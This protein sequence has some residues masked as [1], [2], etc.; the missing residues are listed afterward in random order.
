MFAR[1]TFVQLFPD[2]VDEAIGIYQD[3]YL[4]EAKQQQGNE[5]G[6]LLVDRTTG[7]GISI[8]FWAFE[9]EMIAGE[10]SGH[11]QKQL[12]KFKDFFSAPPVREL[13]EVSAQ[14]LAD[15]KS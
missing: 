1:V 4:P 7:K 5:G 12:A 6:Y 13:Y 2:T 10:T 9:A 14:V 8:S 11:H 15:M 3:S